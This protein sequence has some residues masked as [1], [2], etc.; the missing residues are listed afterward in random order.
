MSPEELA[1]IIASKVVPELDIKFMVQF[2]QDWL[3]DYEISVKGTKVMFK[4]D[5]EDFYAEY[6]LRLMV[7]M[8]RIGELERMFLM[9]AIVPW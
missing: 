4:N 3:P 8:Y 2:L 6:P 5:I 9:P 7:E 1:Y